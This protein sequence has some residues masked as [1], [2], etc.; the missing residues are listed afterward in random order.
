MKINKISALVLGSSVLFAANAFA[1]QEE[2]ISRS[3]GYD[4]MPHEERTMEGNWFSTRTLH[5]KIR[6]KGTE[7]NPISVT[8]LKKRAVVNGLILPEGN[9]MTV[10]VHLGDNMHFELDKRAKL[11]L[12]NNGDQLVNLNC[13]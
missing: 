7:A 13:D 6:A 1:G 5:C 10:I 3:K 12:L 9:S 4:L 2:L 8:A 11:G